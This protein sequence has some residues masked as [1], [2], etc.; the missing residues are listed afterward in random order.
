MNNQ[1]MRKAEVLASRNYSLAV[2]KDKTAD[3]QPIFLAKN[4]ELYG[5][6]AQGTSLEDAI[7][8]LE[9][10][11]IDYIY[12]LLEDDQEVPGPASQEVVTGSYAEFTVRRVVQFQ[13]AHQTATGHLAEKP[14]YEASVTT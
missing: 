14:L 9:D 13:K 6:M 1:L 2:F 5:C 10:A 4:P 7:G 11:R 8:N 12:S 3:G